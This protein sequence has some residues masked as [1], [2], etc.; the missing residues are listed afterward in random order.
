MTIS[1]EQN[2]FCF[3]FS[4]HKFITIINL[5]CLS[6]FERTDLLHF[7]NKIMI[8]NEHVFAYFFVLHTMPSK[9][10]KCSW[11]EKFC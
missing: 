4:N 3:E 11:S 7:K 5:N 6:F 8:R 9:Q 1:E 2:F 10:I